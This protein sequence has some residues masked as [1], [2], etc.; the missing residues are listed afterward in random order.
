MDK[1]PKLN[2]KLFIADP[3][4]K[5]IKGEV[6]EF[7][8]KTIVW[9]NVKESSAAKCWPLERLFETKKEAQKFLSER[10]PST[11]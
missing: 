8:C 5:I 3:S 10:K 11:L 1:P 7:C 2:Q 4:G 9:L 6:Q